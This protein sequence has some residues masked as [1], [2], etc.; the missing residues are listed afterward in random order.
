MSK[1]EERCPSADQQWTVGA[2]DVRRSAAGVI[3]ITRQQWAARGNEF[4]SPDEAGAKRLAFTHPLFRLIL[5]AKSSS[6]RRARRIGARS[7]RRASRQ[8]AV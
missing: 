2:A 3:E 7:R 4:T 8:F 5:E 6:A 1:E